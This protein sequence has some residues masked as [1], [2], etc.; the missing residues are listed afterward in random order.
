MTNNP[1]TH[2]FLFHTIPPTSQTL[3]LKHIHPKFHHESLLNEVF[4][5]LMEPIC[6]N[7][8]GRVPTTDFQQKNEFTKK[9]L[10][11]HRSISFGKMKFKCFTNKFSRRM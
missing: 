3:V 5:K 1:L 2:H 10:E 11:N 4:S 8:A 9:I 7:R 6:S